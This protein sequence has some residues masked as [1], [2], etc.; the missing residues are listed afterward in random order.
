MKK[1]PPNH[2]VNERSPYLLQHAHNPVDWHPWGFLST[3]KK[4]SGNKLLVISIG[5]AAC[6]WCH[7]MEHESFSDP[8]VA[9][10]MNDRFI[11]V[12]VDREERPDVDAVYMAA[13]Y[14]TTGRGGWPLNVIALPDQHPVFGGTYFPKHDWLYILTYYADLWEKQPEKLTGQAGQIAAGMQRHFVLPPDPGKNAVPEDFPVMLF[15]SMSPGLDHDNGGTW[16]APKFPMP[17]N[18][19]FMLEY[20]SIHQDRRAIDHVHLTLDRMWRGGIYDH[21]AGGFS[22]Y[23]TDARWHVPHFEK[24][25]YDNSQLVSLYAG[26][27][28]SHP[29]PTWK[30][31]VTET[32]TF[33]TRELM[34]PEGLFYASLDADSEGREG[35]F[36]TWTAA[37]LRR[38]LGAKAQRFMEHYGCTETGNWEGGLNVL[39]RTK[40]SGESFPGERVLLLAERQKRIRPATDDKVLTAWNG[41]MISALSDAWQAF[42]VEEW[43]EMA[44][45]A[46]GFYL[47]QLRRTDWRLW[48]VTGN[49]IKGPPAFLDDYTFLA[50]AFADLYQST[51]EEHWLDGAV[52]L[53][54]RALGHFQDKD[55]IFFRLIPDDVPRLVTEPIELSD[56]V[57]P[58]SNSVMAHNLLI[59]GTILGDERWVERSGRMLTAMAP[60]MRANPDFHAH[61][62]RL[63]LRSGNRLIHIAISGH[64]PSEVRKEFF[65]HPLS[66]VVWSGSKLPGEPL[67]II[68]CKGKSCFAPVGD[69]MQVFELLKI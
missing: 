13:A 26:A 6:H 43:M 67:K 63:S 54:R 59:L 57:I 30:E 42:G 56:N 22:R 62:G 15:E 47:E 44:R 33:V 20:G 53:T 16:G 68:V 23:S 28:R 38:V 10:V 46:G 69:A 27:S 8:E 58:A 55:G 3:D 64:D 49:E 9:Q 4:S 36:Y 34:N 50:T 51:F 5:Y 66:G 25:L 14:A 45:R 60:K 18:L 2:L 29:E 17:G 21:I 39:H 41:L 7:V 19:L 12:K 40:P 65:R 35:S 37:E 31:V 11:S 52:R 1:N 32:I 61:W 24:M 48:R